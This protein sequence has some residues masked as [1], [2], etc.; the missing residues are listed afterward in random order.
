[1]P[2]PSEFEAARLA[3]LAATHAHLSEIVVALMDGAPPPPPPPVSAAAGPFDPNLASLKRLEAANAYLAEAVIALLDGKPQPR[4]LPPRFDPDQHDPEET[5]PIGV[6]VEDLMRSVR[7][8]APRASKAS[9]G[10]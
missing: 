4:L 1:M 6:R 8:R 5:L 2:T 9:A 7:T 10:R 3:G